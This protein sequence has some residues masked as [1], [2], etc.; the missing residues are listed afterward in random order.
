[1]MQVRRSL[2]HTWKKDL[3]GD[4]NQQEKYEIIKDRAKQLEEQA[5]RK[6]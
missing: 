6:E 1:M 4:L 2:Q 5:L 3:K